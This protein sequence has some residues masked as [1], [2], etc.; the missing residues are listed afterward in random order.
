M[1]KRAPAIIMLFV[2]SVVILLPFSLK[3]PTVSAQGS[4]NIQRVDHEVEV[5]YSGHVVIRDTITISGQLIGDFLIGFPSKYGAY[6]LKGIAY[7]EDNN[8]FPLS[9]GVQ[10]AETGFYGAKVTFKQDSPQVFTVIFILSNSI[11]RQESAGTVFT[12]D[13]PAYPTLTKEV[14]YCEVELI[15]PRNPTVLTITKEDGEITISTFV[16]S[17]LP[18]LTYSPASATFSITSGNLQIITIKELT[19]QITINPAGDIVALE[20]YR[21]TNKSPSSLSSLKIGLPVEASNLVVRDEFGRI[22]TT[23]TLSSSGNTQVFN[24][25]LISSVLSGGSTLLKSEYTLPS[26][27]STAPFTLD[28]DLFPDFDYYIEAARVTFIPP[29]GARFLTP[30]LSEI[31]TSTTLIREPFQETLSISRDG[32]SKVDSAILSENVQ[33]TYDYSPLWL[34]FRPT[35]WVWIIAVIGCVVLVFWKRP[36]E[37]APLQIATSEAYVTLSSEQVRS[38]T[39]AYDEKSRLNS[40]LQNLEVRAQKG[41]IARRRYKVQKRTLELRLDNISKNISDLK[42]T[43]RS[44]GG[45]YANLVRQLDVAEAELVEVEANTRNIDVR[46][47]KGALPLDAYKKAKMDYQR[48]KERAEATINGILLR[49]R[50]ETR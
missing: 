16:K 20:T 15:F 47:R 18:A 9:L 27:S 33:V 46:H 36:K 38:F 34:S 49:L 25:T 12:L 43:F 17:N 10:L 31:D 29:E 4:Y 1:V 21:F 50:E 8:V 14:A 48:R 42:K 37:A 30:L 26:I 11:L 23:T 22:L 35:L 13:F 3:T 39:E 45:N 28:F 24:L 6:V 44:A 41:K 7:D 2:F 40:E 5:M 19:R 32:V